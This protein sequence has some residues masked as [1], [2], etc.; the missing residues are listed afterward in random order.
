MRFN[1]PH[2]KNVTTGIGQFFLHLLDTHFPKNHTPNKTFAKNKINY[3]DYSCMQN[4]KTII[5]NPNMGTVH[6]NDKIKEGC[7]CIN[8]KYRPLSGK[9]LSPNIV[10]QG[11]VTLS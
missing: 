8:K 4:T 6:P 5:N 1:P 9:C 7:K 3:V 11:K 10:C 2:S